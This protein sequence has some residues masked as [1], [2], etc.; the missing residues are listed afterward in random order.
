[1]YYYKENI[2]KQYHFMNYYIT[3]QDLKTKYGQ[4][5]GWNWATINEYN[6]NQKTSSEFN[7]LF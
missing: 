3:K 7:F 4:L 2:T 6:A 1:M 5:L